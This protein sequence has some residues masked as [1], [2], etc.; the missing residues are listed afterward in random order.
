MIHL[1]TRGQGRECLVS[2][3]QKL[4]GEVEAGA[5]NHTFKLFNRELLDSDLGLHLYHNSQKVEKYGSQ[6]GLRLAAALK[7]Y[8]LVHHSVWTEL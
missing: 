1:R 5:G 6:L 4:M 2:A 8:G 3:V 7:E